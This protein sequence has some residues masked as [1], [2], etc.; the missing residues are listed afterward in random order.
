MQ[1]I[2]TH[3]SQTS[4]RLIQVKN[5][6]VHDRRIGE[7]RNSHARLEAIA[8]DFTLVNHHGEF[9][10]LYDSL[11]AN[12]V[13]INFY[14]LTDEITIDDEQIIRL[15]KKLSELN[16]QH[17][18][19]SQDQLFLNRL[20]QNNVVLNINLLHDQ[21]LGAFLKYGLVT[22]EIETPFELFEQRKKPY[23]PAD[24]HVNAMYLIS[25]NKRIKFSQINFSNHL[26][27]QQALLD[28]IAQ[29]QSAPAIRSYHDT[30]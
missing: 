4:Q 10:T 24:L 26:I 17:F 14:S 21:H 19:V 12:P 22:R 23:F 13:V 16:I 27:H 11:E 25:K 18:V 28:E 7:I 5:Q 30:H 29:L 9:T 6:I 20:S 1:A 3:T 8:E 2:Q 15:N